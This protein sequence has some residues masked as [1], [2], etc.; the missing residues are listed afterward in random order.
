MKRDGRGLIPFWYY[1]SQEW[2]DSPR[3]EYVSLPSTLSPW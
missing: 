2:S 1:F 3:L